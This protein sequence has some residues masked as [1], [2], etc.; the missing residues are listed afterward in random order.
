MYYL[1]LGIKFPG[2]SRPTYAPLPLHFLVLLDTNDMRIAVL[3]A[4]PRQWRFWPV[5]LEILRSHYQLP[6]FLQRNKLTLVLSLFP[7]PDVSRLITRRLWPQLCQFNCGTHERWLGKFSKAHYRRRNSNLEC[8]P[9][10]NVMYVFLYIYLY[11]FHTNEKKQKAKLIPFFFFKTY[12]FNRMNSLPYFFG[13]GT[14]LF[15]FSSF[16]IPVLM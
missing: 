12:L 5:P 2:G 4:F 13:L 15:F 3:P 14:P 8:L 1:P 10:T 16:H 6:T 7:L 11:I 9:R